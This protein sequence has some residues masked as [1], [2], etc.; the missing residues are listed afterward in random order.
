MISNV[1]LTII[2]HPIA[3]VKNIK[4]AMQIVNQKPIKSNNGSCDRHVF[5]CRLLHEQIKGMRLSRHCRL[6]VDASF[7]LTTPIHFSSLIFFQLHCLPKNLSITHLVALVMESQHP[8]TPIYK[9]KLNMRYHISHYSHM[10]RS[11]SLPSNMKIGPGSAVNAGQPRPGAEDNTQP[12]F[13]LFLLG[14]GEKKV[15]EEPDTREF[16]YLSLSKAANLCCCF[17]MNSYVPRVSSHG[18]SSFGFYSYAKWIPSFANQC[19]VVRSGIPS[20]S[21]FTFNKEDHTLG[22]LLRSQLLKS[23]HVRFAGYKVPH[24]LVR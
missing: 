13:E 19:C 6:S 7:T 18:S 2:R 1:I 21:I 22:N 8:S 16:S 4:M 20:S 14:E 10:T 24:P 12:R 3:F 17:F 9:N 15:T 11:R 5:I 23:P